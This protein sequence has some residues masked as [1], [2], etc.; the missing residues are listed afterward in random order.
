MLEHPVERRFKNIATGELEPFA[1]SV[2]QIHGVIS[3]EFY[4]NTKLEMFNIDTTLKKSTMVA[5][6]AQKN[7]L[8]C[9]VT[10]KRARSR[11]AGDVGAIAR[12]RTQKLHQMLFS[13][14][15]D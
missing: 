8:N 9:M 5:K 6:V 15:S 7:G 11:P 10:D 4:H 14:K 12:L 3:P 1:K 13:G 2:S